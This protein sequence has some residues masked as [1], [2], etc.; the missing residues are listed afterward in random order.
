[1]PKAL[2]HPTI[3]KKK[4][5]KFKKHQSDEYVKVKESWRR[6]RGIDSRQRRKFRRYVPNTIQPPFHFSVVR[7][8]PIHRARAKYEKGALVAHAKSR[9]G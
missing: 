2:P 4:S 8:Q 1:M 5:N 9:L 3:V 6:P 7:G